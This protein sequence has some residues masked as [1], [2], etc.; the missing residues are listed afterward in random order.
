MI[1]PQLPRGRGW[2]RIQ[3]E[4]IVG[5]VLEVPKTPAV[6]D[7]GHL[8]LVPLLQ[9]I[10]AAI[11][12]YLQHPSTISGERL[13]KKAQQY[14]VSRHPIPQ[15]MVSQFPSLPRPRLEQMAYPNLYLYPLLGSVHLRNLRPL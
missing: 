5:K 3:M 11:L 8:R 4:A 1:H 2:P 15:P 9:R 7:T 6:T 10:P 13:T 14:P 12:L